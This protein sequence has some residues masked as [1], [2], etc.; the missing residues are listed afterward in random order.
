M[1]TE[2]RWEGYG[3]DEHSDRYESPPFFAKENH[4]GL[5]KS[6]FARNKNSPSCR[7]RPCTMSFAPGKW[8]LNT[9]TP[10][11]RLFEKNV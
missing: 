2:D 9:G 4:Q 5:V 3:W 7:P 10:T 6:M 1:I 11:V 8:V